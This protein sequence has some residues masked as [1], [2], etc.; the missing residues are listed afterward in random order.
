MY[1]MWT[2]KKTTRERRKLHGREAGSVLKREYIFLEP[3]PPFT[4][5]PSVSLKS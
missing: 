3:L 5:I 2:A 4:M 1:M